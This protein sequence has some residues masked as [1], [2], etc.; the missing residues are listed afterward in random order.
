[1]QIWQIQFSSIHKKSPGSAYCLPLSLTSLTRSL[2]IHLFPHRMGLR[3]SYFGFPSATCASTYMGRGPPLIIVE[4]VGVPNPLPVPF[5]F[6]F[7]FPVPLPL[8]FPPRF[9]LRRHLPLVLV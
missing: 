6:P 2:S 1:M 3:R 9:P 7:L 8:R 5:P 4:E